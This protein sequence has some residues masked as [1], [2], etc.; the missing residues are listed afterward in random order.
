MPYVIKRKSDGH[1][2]K[3]VKTWSFTP[4]LQRARIFLRKVDASNS[5]EIIY[6]RPASGR[7]PVSLQATVPAPT[8]TAYVPPLPRDWTFDYDLVAVTHKVELV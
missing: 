7:V 3:A 5:L 4:D 2:R 6:G 8:V 1:Y